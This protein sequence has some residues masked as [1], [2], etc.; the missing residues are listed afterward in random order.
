MNVFII[1]LKK[2]C[3]WRINYFQWIMKAKKQIP[4]IRLDYSKKIEAAILFEVIPRI[5]IAALFCKSFQAYFI[6]ILFIR[7]WWRPPS[8]CVEKNS[9]RIMSASSVLMKRPGI[10]RI[11]ASLCWRA[12][13]AI[14]AFQQSAA[15]TPWCLFSVILIPFP[16]PQI[17]IP[18]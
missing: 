16:L 9:V 14:S 1:N 11:L 7:F 15:R 17:A 13:C 5:I 2:V 8:N 10:T 6:G 3:V 4:D 18:G 12:R